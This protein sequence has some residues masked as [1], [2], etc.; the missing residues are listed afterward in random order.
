MSRKVYRMAM[1]LV[2]AISIG[3]STIGYTNPVVEAP[4]AG[5]MVADMVVARPMLLVATLAGVATYIVSLP[6]SLAG[7]NAAEA[8]QILVAG[9]AK[10]TFV[11]CLGCTISGRSTTD[12]VEQVD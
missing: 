10:A 2:A 4:S 11:R 8:G 9:P 5:K 12:T 3:F 7:G 1:I 6:F